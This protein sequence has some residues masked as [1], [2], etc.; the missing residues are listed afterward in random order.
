MKPVE[1]YF[2]LKDT[3][4]KV[5][6]WDFDISDKCS[7]MEVCTLKTGDYS[8]RGLENVLCIERKKTVS[9]F[10]TN[11]H[12][13][14]FKD[15]VER[16]SQYKH[17]F[18]IL[19]FSIDDILRFPVGSNIPKKI[20]PKLRVTS[21]RLLSVIAK[22]QVNYGINVVFAGDVSNAVL[23]AK[24]IMYRTQILYSGGSGG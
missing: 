2:V 24:N 10:A 16:L 14:R 11:I 22:L 4:E 7:G 8:L 19:E 1:P 15:W 3:R 23:L 6:G 13:S 20:W 18:L 21:E 17:P 5:G 12:E 9:E